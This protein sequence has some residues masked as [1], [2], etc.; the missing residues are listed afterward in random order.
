MQFNSLGFPV[1]FLAVYGVYLLLRRSYK[2]QNALL[3]GASYF[4]YG[5]WDWRFCS[6]LLLSTVVDY[7]IG[8][9]LARTSDERVRKRLVTAS[10]VTNL[11]ILGFFKYFNFFAENVSAALESLGMGAHGWT[12]SVVLPVG[13]SFYTFQTMS[14]TIDI[15]RRKMEPASSPLDFALFVSF[16]PQLVAG[17]IERARTLLP[18]ISGP[19][20]LRA[21]QLDAGVHLL[22]W[23]FFKKVV[24]SD[25]LVPI[26][27]EVFGRTAY[28]QYEG[29]DVVLGG[30][31]FTLHLYCDFSGYSDIA[32]G[33][34]KLMGFEFS[35]NFRLPFFATSPSDLW[36]RWHISLSSWLRDY[37]Y[38]PLG[39]NRGGQL[40]T[41]RNLMLTMLLG[42]LWH[43]ASW[44]FVLWG[45]YQ[46]TL[47]VAHRNWTLA[48][49]SGAAGGEIGSLR[50][51]LSIAVMFPLTVLGFLIM[52]ADS[53]PQLAHHLTHL[54]L[55]ASEHTAGF[56]SDIAFFAGPLLVVQLAQHLS[57]DLMV[58]MRL[59]S[60]LRVGLYGL[61]LSGLFLFGARVP[62]EFF[63]FQF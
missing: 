28:L 53:L 39:G 60:V 57:G 18:Q 22:V 29:L 35:V 56:A 26:T 48:T 5:Y 58:L 19:R 11:S 62:V 51:W 25:N 17:P 1:F 37:L 46:G 59:P 43:G 63:Y 4:F 12:L 2:L 55:A 27:A 32:R 41:Q 30:L 45:A 47:L 6:L 52:R 8:G 24:I 21:D 36:N 38:I 34:A 61:L 49:G 14:Y 13:I 10:V 31:A 9:R 54:G 20:T 15:Y 42:G 44:P 23:G 33:L 7:T 16:F 3:L 50:G 40:A